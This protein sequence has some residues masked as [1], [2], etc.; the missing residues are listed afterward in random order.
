MIDRQ[1]NKSGVRIVKNAEIDEVMTE[2]A[3]GIERAPAITFERFG[4][5]KLW[6]GKAVIQPGAKTGVH[7]H[8]ELES[9][10]I[11]VSG[12]AR[13]RWG[14]RLEYSAEAG[15]G[16]IIYVPPFVPHQEINA[17]KG[18]PLVSVLIRSD[19]DPVMVSLDVPESVEV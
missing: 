1:W 7:H 12:R 13:M 18:E 4:A 9:V 2:V 11:V 14:D 19:K 6:V 3:E 16:D 8:G 15:P 17:L 5:E 10:I